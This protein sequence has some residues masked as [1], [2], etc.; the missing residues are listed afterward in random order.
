[1]LKWTLIVFFNFILATL[2]FGFESDSTQIE[3]DTVCWND[4]VVSFAQDHLGTPY[5]YGGTSPSGFDC[6]GFVQY[7]FDHFDT[8][9]PRTSSSYHHLNDTVPLEQVQVGDILVF[10][11]TDPSIRKPGHLGIVTKITE[12]EI[13]F[14]H[15]SSS[16][17][18]PGVVE[19]KL[20]TTGYRKR[21]IKTLRLLS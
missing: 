20:Y 15:S 12:N 16:K 19:S 18:H 5:K 10:T 21:Y 13:I 14:I 7:V 11:G 9:L 2:A 1:M 6:S 3:S 17:K 4:S 8:D